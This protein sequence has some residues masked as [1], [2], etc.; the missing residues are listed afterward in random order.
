MSPREKFYDVEP[1]DVDAEEERARMY[2]AAV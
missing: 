1:M 2:I